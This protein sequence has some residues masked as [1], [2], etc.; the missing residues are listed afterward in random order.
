MWT[1]RFL[2]ALPLAIC[3]FLFQSYFWVPTYETQAR[4]TPGRLGQYISASIGDAG[5]LNPILNADS[6]SSRICGLVFE[7]LIDRDEDLNFRGRLAE[8]WEISEEAY[9]MVDPK[10]GRT[11]EEAADLIRKA[12]SEGAAGKSVLAKCLRNISAVDVAPAET[13]VEKGEEMMPGEDGKPKQVEV[14]VNINRPKRVKLALRNVD[15][16][17]FKTLEEVLGKGSSSFDTSGYIEISPAE[18]AG[19]RAA[20]AAMMCPPSEHNPIIVFH[21]RKGVKFHDGHEF[22][23]GDVKF[24]YES[25]IDPK[26]LSPR[27]PDYEPVKAVEV[28]DPH[29]VRIVYKR[30][31]SPAFGT[32]GMGILPEHLLNAERMA[33][34]AKARDIAPEDFSMDKS[35]FNRSPIGCGPF[36]FVEWKSDEHIKL[37]RFIDYW[38]GPPEYREY[39][40]RI[41]PDPLTQEMEFYAGMLDSYGAEPH[42]VA[43]LKKDEQFQNFSGLS[44]GYTYIGYNM[45]REPFNDVRVRRA[46][47]MA[48]DVDLII[49][50]VLYD[51]GESMTGPFPKQTDFYDHEIAPPTYDPEGAL[52]LL[53]EAG[54][55]KNADGWL[56]KDGKTLSFTLIT[57]NGNLVRKDVLTIA[58]NSWKKIGVDVKTDLLEWAVFISKHVN[59]GDFDALIL[60]WGMGFDPD[61]YQI[62]HSSQSGPKQLNFVAFR[63]EEAD[64]LIVR[65]RQEYDHDRQ[66]EMCHRLHQIIVDEQPYTF[67]FVRKWTALLDKRI[68]VARKS[69]DGE[70]VGYEKIKPTK[71]GDYQYYFNRWIKVAEEPEITAE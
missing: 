52:K 59:T 51:Q 4:A 54:W 69:D 36:R 28:I 12:I 19:N 44:L 49:K 37:D 9:L 45:R 66:V 35:T 43:R 16:D 68:Y 57:N 53:A 10:G 18:L 46:L 25:I 24:T 58:Q 29:T 41:I 3:A 65:I 38:E 31:Y 7:G 40:Y 64:D 33:E 32:W 21:L 20:Y 34:E 47:G 26:N 8:S 17:L 56:E 42:Q 48:I 39:V 14:T 55:R 70:T 61:L 13:A 50:Y 71:T 23:A 5:K 62:W 2:I 63:N 30:L 60:G 6:A 27:V 11:V 15:Q 67:L 1:K 22:D